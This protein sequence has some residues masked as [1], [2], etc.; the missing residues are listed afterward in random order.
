MKSGHNDSDSEAKKDDKKSKK[1][2]KEK[3]RDPRKDKKKRSKK[4]KRDDS[5]TSTSGSEAS[6][7]DDSSDKSP[8]KS[9][10]DSKNSIRVQMRNLQDSNNSK[11][12]NDELTGKWTMVNDKPCPPPAPVISK[13]PF[14]EE[15][16]EDKA[17][18][19]WNA[20][21]PI[22]SNEER[23]MLENLKGKMKS[24]NEP[25]KPAAGDRANSRNKSRSRSRDRNYRNRRSR[26]RSRSRSRGRFARR[27]RSR[28]RRRD[29]R[30][31]SRS[32]SRG[33]RDRRDAPRNFGNDSK[34]PLQE[35]RQPARSYTATAK[36]DS[37][38]V[39]KVMPMIGKMPVFKKQLI[40]K[41]PEEEVVMKY[42]EEVPLKTAVVSESEEPK[43]TKEDIAWDDF[44]PD[45]MQYS[46]IMC[47]PPPPL[48]PEVEIPPGL[49]PLMDSEFIPQPI[50]DAPIPM[51][52]PLPKDFQ[53]TLDLLYDGDKPKQIIHELKEPLPPAVDE[54][55][56]SMDYLDPSI[57]TMMTAEEMSKHAMMYGG[58]M[59]QNADGSN[60]TE[61]L[62]QSDMS[63]GVG[64]AVASTKESN[65]ADIVGEDEEG[66][67]N[68]QADMDDLAMLGI[69]VNDVGSG[70]W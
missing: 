66:E 36:R 17:L 54:A 60:P 26:T 19:K 14:V 31:R 23:R 21:D 63:D 53:E 8:R 24:R 12:R 58:F 4:R 56:S 38:A 43:R 6:D 59:I 46:A 70:F 67:S 27:S 40:D 30:S 55:P 2:K 3:K 25:A 68:Q 7:T 15:K 61:H 37:A 9:E 44:M 35:K 50:S 69:D 1:N 32:N 65:G 13:N 51:K 11:S 34:P 64:S 33:R 47:V 62:M 16:K 49:D 22:M 48:E 10:S 18:G 57:P 28:S 5:S 45:P 20:V 41:K 29:Q 39:K 52:G 42:E